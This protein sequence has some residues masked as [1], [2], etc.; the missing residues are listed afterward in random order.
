AL[1][2]GHPV[3]REYLNLTISIDHDLVDGAPAA[4]FTKRLKELIESGYG[5]D[6]GSAT[7]NSEQA[8]HSQEVNH[9]YAGARES[10]FS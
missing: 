4:R 2:D 9:V 8:T 1:V 10:N 6:L 3:V 7:T 5:L